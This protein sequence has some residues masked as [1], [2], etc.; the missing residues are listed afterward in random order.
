MVSLLLRTIGRRSS[1]R[2]VNVQELL[3][4][5]RV[6]LMVPVS[7]NDGV[8]LVVLVHFNWVVDDERRTETVNVLT[9]QQGR[10]SAFDGLSG[11]TIPYADVR[12]PLRKVTIINIGW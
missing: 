1:S 5:D 6:L 10:A 3:D 2:V 11:D 9:L 4:K 12:V 8:L 7:E